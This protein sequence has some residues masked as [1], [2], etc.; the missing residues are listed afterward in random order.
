MVC[1][2]GGN[3]E[4]QSQEQV[5]TWHAWY[6]VL[7]VIAFIVITSL[8]VIGCV[9]IKGRKEY[10]ISGRRPLYSFRW[11]A[12]VLKRTVRRK[13][14]TQ[15]RDEGGDEDQRP[16]IVHLHRTDNSLAMTVTKTSIRTLST[17]T[18]NYQH[19]RQ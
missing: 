14:K 7:I 8:A 6:I 3:T 5:S 1:G 12:R 15:L 19:Q 10:K 4:A 16:Y 17:S 11:T 2:G 13:R 18:D 9:I